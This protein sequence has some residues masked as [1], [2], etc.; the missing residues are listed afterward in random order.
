MSGGFLF[1]LGVLLLRLALILACTTVFSS[2][3]F[4]LG[5]ILLYC[6]SHAMQLRKQA[7]DPPRGCAML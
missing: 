7:P 5:L 6:E 2:F 4:T 1:G 3:F